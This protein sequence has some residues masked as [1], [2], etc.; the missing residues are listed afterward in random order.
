MKNILIIN[1]RRYGDILST[2]HLINSILTKEKDASISLLIYEEFQGITKLL[3]NI[4]QVFT[5]KRNDILTLKKN[6]LFNDGL[7]IDQF[8]HDINNLKKI[9]WSKIINYS[10]DPISSYLTSYI[11]NLNQS[12]FYGVSYNHHNLLSYSNGWATVFNDILPTFRFTPFNFVDVYHRLSET[13]FISEGEKI[14]TRPAH[15]KMAFDNISKIR[16][17]AG[18]GTELKI[19]GIQLKTSDVSKDI[20]FGEIVKLVDLLL[21]NPEYYPIL[22]VAPTE[23]EKSYANRINKYFNNTLVSVEADFLALSSVLLNLDLLVTPDTVIKH[24]ADLLETPLVEVSLGQSPFFK[25]GT[26]NPHSIILTDLVS[27]RNFRIEK[28]KEP[29]TN[30]TGHD[31]YNAVKCFFDPRLDNTLTFTSKVSLYRP[32]KDD[33]G[34]NYTCT[35]GTKDHLFDLSRSMSRV[36]LL[37]IL[38]VNINT[39][40]H[41]QNIILEHRHKLKEWMETQKIEISEASKCLLSALRNLLSIKEKKAGGKDFAHSLEIL[42][43]ICNTNSLASLATL[44]FRSKIDNLSSSTMEQNIKDVELLLFEL[45]SN[46]Q[47]I[48]ESTREL[49]SLFYEDKKLETQRTKSIE[50]TGI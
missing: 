42:L 2:G 6:A 38:K 12:S 24:L 20:P 25:Q 33:V 8:A 36:A 1:L 23:E 3:K 28:N 13:I 16:K 22:L 45:K 5:I 14:L 7:A 18:N 27:S 50:V 31:I 37:K 35:S 44:I 32:I 34:I 40:I 30:I 49:E 9:N 21:N 46:L 10:N 29:E 48:M 43:D 15:N 4:S 39:K 17:S 11:N 26:I 19:I 41:Y 47:I